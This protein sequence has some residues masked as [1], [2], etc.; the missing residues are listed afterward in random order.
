[1]RLRITVSFTGSAPFTLIGYLVTGKK[2]AF[3]LTPLSDSTCV[4]RS[5]SE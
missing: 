4:F 1:M 3:G 5:R 2:G